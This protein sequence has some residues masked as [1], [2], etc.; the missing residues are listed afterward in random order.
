VTTVSPMT[1]PSVLVALQS[2]ILVIGAGDD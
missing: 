2:A 1:A